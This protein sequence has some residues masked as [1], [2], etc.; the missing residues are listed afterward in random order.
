VFLA[1]ESSVLTRTT[2]APAV[3]MRPTERFQRYITHNACC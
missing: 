2:G 1:S 3:L